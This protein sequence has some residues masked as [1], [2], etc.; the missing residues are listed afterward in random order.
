MTPVGIEAINFYT[1][2]VFVDLGTIAKVRNID[3]NK[4]YVGIGQHKMS[5]PAVDED[6][7]TLAAN[8][9]SPLMTD[10]NR[11]TIDNVFFA[12]ESGIDQSKSAGIYAHSLLGIQP[13][14]RVI[15]LKQACYS[16]AAAIRFAA[17]HVQQNPDKKVLVL[18]AD[19]ARYGLNT[20]GEPSQGCGAVA[21][22]ISAKPTVMT[23]EPESGCYTQD[24][25]DFWRPNYREEGLVDGKYSSKMYLASLEQAWKQYQVNSGRSFEDHKRFC[26]HT[27]VPRLVEKAHRFLNK[28]CGKDISEDLAK[29]QMH[30]AIIYNRISGNCYAASL[31][32]SLVSLIDNCRENLAGE[33]I[34][35][36]SYGSGSVAEVFSGVLS[37]NYKSGS[38]ANAHRNLLENRIEL[39][40]D[41]YKNLYHFQLPIDGSD[42]DLPKQQTGPYRLASMRR[43]KRIYEDS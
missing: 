12:T 7:V 31:Y 34:A 1:S 18:A 36:Y 29:E 15:E 28:V 5:V 35:F 3:V 24:I 25:M 2:N 32:I 8:A 39:T 22:L 38:N 23:L 16:G 20:P 21:I 10:E 19:V 9:A 37:E 6:I 26:Y 40:Y 11:R 27:P 42:L 14:C 13:H 4:Y 43:H 30:D 33:R 41:E 17:L